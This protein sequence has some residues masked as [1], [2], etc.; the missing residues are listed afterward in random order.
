VDI[1]LHIDMERML[2]TIKDGGYYYSEGWELP[3]NPTFNIHNDK[4]KQRMYVEIKDV[5]FCKLHSMYLP[6]HPVGESVKKQMAGVAGDV[7]GA[8]SERG[9]RRARLKR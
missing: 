8:I 2:V 3:P 5:G 4:D 6:S 9:A 1:N 7:P